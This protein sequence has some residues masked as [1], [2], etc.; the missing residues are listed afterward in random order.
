MGL[1]QVRAGGG[2]HDAGDERPLEHHDLDSGVEVVA[3]S[4]D[5]LPLLSFRLPSVVVEVRPSLLL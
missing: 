1:Q 2:E 4:Q 3:V 5:F